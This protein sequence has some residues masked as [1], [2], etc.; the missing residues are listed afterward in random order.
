MIPSFQSNKSP[1]QSSDRSTAKHP[2]I[3]VT[4]LMDS[5]LFFRSLVS[6]TKSSIGPYF[7]THTWARVLRFLLISR[8]VTNQIDKERPQ[9]PRPSVRD[10][11]GSSSSGKRKG[12]ESSKGKK[13][14]KKTLRYDMK[15]TISVMKSRQ[16]Q[17]KKKTQGLRTHRQFG[18]Y[19]KDSLLAFVS[20]TKLRKNKVETIRLATR[21]YGCFVVDRSDDC[22]GLLL[23]WDFNEILHSSKKKGGRRRARVHMEDFQRSLRDANLWYIRP[24]NGWF[25]WVGG[26]RAHTF[27][28][29]RIDRVV[30]N[31]DWQL[32][33]LGCLVSTVP[34]ACTNHCALLLS[35]ESVAPSRSHRADYFKFDVFWATEEQ[36]GNIA[37]GMKCVSENEFFTWIRLRSQTLFVSNDTRPWR[38]L[39]SSSI[40]MKPSGIR[41]LGQRA[42]SMSL[43]ATSPLFRSSG[44]EPDE[45]IQHAIDRCVTPM[46]NEMLSRNF[47]SEEVIQAF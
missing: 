44:A 38:S 19:G 24:K 1:T 41:D 11:V 14:F 12:G 9:N 20:E 34:T 21:M 25:T 42:S 33:F 28:K 10:E 7:G 36:Y 26:T 31:K 23:L 35:L 47:T 45:E 5:T 8:R 40:R 17:V 37:K 16:E 15:T 3:R 46:D 18:S 43:L 13:K 30:S 32:M 27:V 29:E 6:E 22:V 39:R 4:S 2:Y